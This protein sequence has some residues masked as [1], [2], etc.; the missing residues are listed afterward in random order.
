V[1]RHLAAASI[2]VLGT[3]GVIGLSLGMNAVVG[4]SETEPVA[5]VSELPA[6][7]ASKPPSQKR[8]RRPAPARKARRAAPSAAPA[9]AASLG[10]LDFG[11]GDVGAGGL[12][13]ATAALVGSMG[14]GVV[15]EEAVQ[16]PPTPVERVAPTFPARARA[17]GQSGSVTLS[18]VVDID[19]S[20]AD[21]HV[22]ESI[23]P[24]V[25]DDAAVEAVRR[26]RFSPGEQDGAPV[27]VRVRQTLRFELE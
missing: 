13:E 2:A 11:F 20:T 5:V 24:G 16:E 22:V 7:A 6:A 27:A 15:N 1:L 23:P 21:V 26:W 3:C 19:G 10:G 25:F 9:L 17:L 4:R 12:T 14:G 8:D 18:F